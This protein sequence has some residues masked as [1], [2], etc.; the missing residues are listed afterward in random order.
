MLNVECCL[1]H[2][3]NI[4][5][6]LCQHLQQAPNICLFKKLI[7]FIDL[8]KIQVEVFLQQSRIGLVMGHNGTISPSVIV[9]NFKRMSPLDGYVLNFRRR[10]PSV[11]RY[12]LQT[13]ESL[14]D[15]I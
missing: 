12:H 10:S 4:T 1:F 9:I 6:H 13:D 5:S 14:C 7:T 8:F 3:A 11:I 2:V 15:T